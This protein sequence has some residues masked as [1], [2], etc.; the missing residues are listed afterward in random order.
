[1]SRQLEQLIE[2]DCKEVTKHDY[3]SSYG[4][5]ARLWQEACY[6]II[7]LILYVFTFHVRRE[8]V[9]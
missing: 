8:R 7:K 2:T 4:R 9:R 5:I 3:D 1:M 6:G